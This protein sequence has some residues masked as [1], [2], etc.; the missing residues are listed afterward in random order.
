M[1]WYVFNELAIL[2]M[3]CIK[4]LSPSLHHISVAIGCI[5]KFISKS[6]NFLQNNFINCWIFSLYKTYYTSRYRFDVFG[7]IFQG[8]LACIV[9][10]LV[11]IHQAKYALILVIFTLEKSSSEKDVNLKLFFGGWLIIKY[12]SLNAKLG[13]YYSY[14]PI[15]LCFVRSRAFN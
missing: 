4:Y 8:L 11:S 5:R 12:L 14:K 15:K 1:L 6:I 13:K 2:L 7:N 9:L 3:Q 10:Q